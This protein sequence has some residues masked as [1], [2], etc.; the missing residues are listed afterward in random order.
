MMKPGI[1]TIRGMAA[2]VAQAA[3]L[4]NAL[5]AAPV[6]GDETPEAALIA[7]VNGERSAAGLAPL[8]ADERL[9]CAARTHAR[10]L[11]AHDRFDHTGSDGGDLASRLGRVGYAYGLAAENLA[12][13]G[14]GAPA[15]VGLWRTSPGHARNMRLTGVRAAGAA[16]VRGR[17]G[18]FV[19]VLVVAAERAGLAD[20]P[21]FL[22]KCEAIPG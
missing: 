7:A 16:R 3:M 22:T 18:R 20:K 1:G 11:A 6:R 17:D 21:S 4:A 5:A 10:D 2:M 8:V 15:I 14:A 9:A 12:L 13:A 19:W